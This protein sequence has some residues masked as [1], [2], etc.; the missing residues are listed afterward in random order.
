[1]VLWNLC[2][3]QLLACNRHLRREAKLEVVLLHTLLACIGVFVVPEREL[4]E[5]MYHHQSNTLAIENLSQYSFYLIYKRSRALFTK[6]LVNN[7]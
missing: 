6:D 1:M 7:L 2:G 4:F 3:E 5:P